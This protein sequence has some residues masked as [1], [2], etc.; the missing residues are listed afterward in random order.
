ETTAMN[1]KMLADMAQSAMGLTIQNAAANQQ[2]VQAIINAN[3]QNGLAMAQANMQ[4]GLDLSRAVTTVSVKRLFDQQMGDAINEG[5]LT[6][7]D[8]QD[9]LSNLGAALSGVQQDIKAAQTTPP[10]TGTGGAFGS[11]PGSAVAAQVAAV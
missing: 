7:S 4:A 9:K 2:T 3:L 6:G 8:L 11:A 1:A 5:T 10:Q